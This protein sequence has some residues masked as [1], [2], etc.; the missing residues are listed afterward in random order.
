MPQVVTPVERRRGFADEI[1]GDRLVM[2]RWTGSIKPEEY[3]FTQTS[4]FAR[5]ATRSSLPT[6]MNL[7][8]F[9][10]THAF[11]NTL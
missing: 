3:V 8:S 4:I 9:I 5:Q 1:V 6:A 7:P 10:A 2:P 11:D